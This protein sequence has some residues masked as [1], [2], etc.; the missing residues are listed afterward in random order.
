MNK[1]NEKEI[2]VIDGQGG[3]IGKL[4]IEGIQEN[5]KKVSIIAVGTNSIA[6]ANMIKGGATKAATG[7][8]PVIAACR[9]ADIIVGP[10]G[11]VIAD[12]LF[13]EITPAMALAIGQSR[14][15]K[16][17]LPMNKCGN[18]V[19]GVKNMPTGELITEALQLIRQYV[20]DSSI[21]QEIK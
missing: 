7:E 3:R 8:N 11:I 1:D 2:L 15:E 20:D 12:A 9:Y 10:I 21:K 5:F 4:L 6:T 19:A 17:L 16:I 18:Q 13:G 14:A